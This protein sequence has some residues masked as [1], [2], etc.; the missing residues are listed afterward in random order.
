MNQD[1]HLTRI[2]TKLR[3]SYRWLGFP[4]VVHRATIVIY[5][6]TCLYYYLV[7]NDGRVTYDNTTIRRPHAALFCICIGLFTSSPYTATLLIEDYIYVY[8]YI[9]MYIYI[10]SSCP[11]YIYRFSRQI[12]EN[13]ITLGLRRICS[14]TSDALWMYMYIYMYT[15][16]HVHVHTWFRWEPKCCETGNLRDR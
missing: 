16:V 3:W 9:H 5:I 1:L 12:F 15:H 10:N 14:Q 4:S 2:V 8:I 7:R 11:T 13:F 6:D